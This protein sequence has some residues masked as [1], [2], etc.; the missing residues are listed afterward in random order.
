MT[1][2]S[3]ATELDGILYSQKSVELAVVQGGDKDNSNPS[4]MVNTI[5]LGA[6][7]NSTVLN[8]GSPCTSQTIDL[9][10]IGLAAGDVYT[11]WLRET[12]A[13]RLLKRGLC[14]LLTGSLQTFPEL[15][16]F[17]RQAPGLSSESDVLTI[18]MDNTHPTVPLDLI[19]CTP[20]GLVSSTSAGRGSTQVSWLGSTQVSWCW[21]S[22]VRHAALGTDP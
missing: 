8:C 3:C 17:N 22:P 11:V 4:Y 10:T 13:I 20:L 9:E 2:A 12:N 5:Q 19:P 21:T 15:M 1:C 18:I 7:W 6:P 16:T 14:R